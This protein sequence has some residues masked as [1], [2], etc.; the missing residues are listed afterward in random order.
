M[1]RLPP[2]GRAAASHPG[3]RAGRTRDTDGISAC[4]DLT[5]SELRQI[6]SAL[7]ISFARS[8]TRRG[9]VKNCPPRHPFCRPASRRAPPP[10]GL[11]RHLRPARYSSTAVIAFRPPRD[12]NHHRLCARSVVGRQDRDLVNTLSLGSLGSCEAHAYGALRRGACERQQTALA[13]RSRPA[14]GASRRRRRVQAEAIGLSVSHVGRAARDAGHRWPRVPE[15]RR[16]NARARSRARG[17]HH[18]ANARGHRRADRSPGAR[19]GTWSSIL[20]K[21]SAADPQRRRRRVEKTEPRPSADRRA[22]ICP[23]P[24][25]QPNFAR[26]TSSA[27]RFPPGTTAPTSSLT[28]RA[29][30]APTNKG[31]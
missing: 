12:P 15:V 29:P 22:A 3:H 18:Q 25:K 17:A 4:Q 23:R 24:Q 2:I 16:S 19:S 5:S 7:C 9:S 27:K 6:L 11:L 10:T 1:T 14:G 30:L 26:F 8:K 20:G 13:D 31:L 21:P 28:A